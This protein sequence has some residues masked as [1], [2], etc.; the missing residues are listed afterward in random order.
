MV[1]VKKE[2]ILEIRILSSTR[3][4]KGMERKSESEKHEQENIVHEG[5]KVHGLN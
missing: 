5:D 1:R 4:S 2:K 3:V